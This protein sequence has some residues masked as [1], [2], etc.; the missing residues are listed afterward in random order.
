MALETIHIYHTNDIHSHLDHWSEIAHFIKQQRKLHHMKNEETLLFDIGDH[1]DRFDSITEGLSGK[2]N[3]ELLN[4]LKYD[5]ATIGNNEGITFSKEELDSLYEKAEFQVLVANLFH[6]NGESPSWSKAYDIHHLKN[7]L[8]VGVIGITIPYYSFYDMLGWKIADAWEIL[9]PLIKKLRPKVDILILLSH[10]G[11]GWDVQAAEA[12]EGID[13]IIGAHTHHLLQQGKIVKGTL[14]AQAGKFGNYV[15]QITLTYDRDMKQLVS[16]EASCVPVDKMKK[17]ETTERLVQ[18]LREE[19]N[20]RLKEEVAT[21]SKPLQVSWYGQSPFTKLLAESLKEWCNTEISMVNAGILLEGLPQGIVTK[22]DLHRVCPHPINP[23]VVKL[24]G[25]EIKEII[26]QSLRRE[27]VGLTIQGLGFRGKVMGSMIY[28]G[29]S[30][31]IQQLS[32]GENRARDIYI[33][34]KPLDPKET[35]TIATIDMFT[36]GRLYPAIAQAKEKRYFLPEMLRDLLAWKLG[37]LF[38]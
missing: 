5:N 17:N 32:D 20:H 7:G 15:G 29:I 13:V 16:T 8:K 3:I 24:K 9:P 31:E 27:V 35:Y 23:C 33:M 18:R 25:S 6:K 10:M 4:E 37:H 28:D 26:A 14:I 1:C 34:G 38:A 22:K 36:F 11:Y 12:M 21:L 30:F 19:G 2:G